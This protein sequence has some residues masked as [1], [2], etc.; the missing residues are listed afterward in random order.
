MK[1]LFFALIC[2]VALIFPCYG[3]SYVA[4][5]FDDGPS[6]RFTRHLL[7]GL[8]QRDARATFFLCG[9]RLEQY[10][11]LAKQMVEEGHE[12]GLH[13]FSHDCMGK[14]N[15]EHILGEIAKTE[16]LLPEGTEIKLLRPPGGFCSPAVVQ[17]AAEQGLSLVL[18]SL[19]PKDWEIH[20]AAAV[21]KTVVNK[22]KDGDIILLHDMTDSSVDAALQ[23]VDA[24]TE[25]GF[26][27]VTVSELAELRGKEL[28]PGE[29]YNQFY[30]E[31]S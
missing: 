8:A 31:N 24:L 11:D 5:T 21:K 4:L 12:V 10:P 1:K 29:K 25:K 7:E 6:G 19:D 20:N 26:S 9:Y 27:F 18:W 15:C 28:M 22:A 23:I 3:E 16:A 30:S 13:G 14:M 17:C 2:A